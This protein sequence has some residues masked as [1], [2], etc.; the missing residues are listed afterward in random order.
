MRIL[1]IDPGD[2]NIGVAISDPTATIANPLAV[3][4]YTSREEIAFKIANLA[5]EHNATTIVIGQS[6]NDKGKPT[7]QGRKA[8][9][10]AKAIQKLTKCEVVLFDEYMT[11]QIALQSRIDLNLPR[12]K[13]Q[14]HHD[15]IAATVLL[16]A[17]LDTISNK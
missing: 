2:K 8:F 4:Q 12:K 17:Y 15:E 5:K 6:L 7:Y 13:R 1:G 16:Q 3:I 10:L 11:T 9:R 14:G